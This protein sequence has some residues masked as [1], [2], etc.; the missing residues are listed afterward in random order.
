MML[1]DQQTGHARRVQARYASW[2]APRFW[3][4]AHT[5]K[6]PG[7][8]P[9]LNRRGIGDAATVVSLLIDQARDGSFAGTGERVV[10]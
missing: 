5:Q 6:Q 7:L 2:G 10:A 4:C 8:E 9:L 1:T 3:D